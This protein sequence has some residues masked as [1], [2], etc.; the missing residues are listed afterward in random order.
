MHGV[1]TKILIK[2][3]AVLNGPTNGG[4]THT[5]VNAYVPKGV[6]KLLPDANRDGLHYSW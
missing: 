6:V 3:H 2:L 4:K 5:E 1:T